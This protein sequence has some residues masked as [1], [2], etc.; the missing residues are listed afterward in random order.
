MV[1]ALVFLGLTARTVDLPAGHYTVDEVCIAAREAGLDCSVLSNVKDRVFAARLVAVEPLAALKAL[2]AAAGDLEVKEE[3][4]DGRTV[5]TVQ[6]DLKKRAENDALSARVFKELIDQCK[7]D[8]ES[9]RRLRP[10]VASMSPEDRKTNYR[11]L[12]EESNIVRD[13][14]ARDLDNL[15]LKERLDEL[16]VLMSVYST[17]DRPWNA[18]ALAAIEIAQGQF[19]ASFHEAEQWA[20]R[21][22]AHPAMESLVRLAPSSAQVIDVGV[23]MHQS[24]DATVLSLRPFVWIAETSKTDSDFLPVSGRINLTD[25]E[26]PDFS[27]HFAQTCAHFKKID[28]VVPEVKF[29]ATA[30]KRVV[31]VKIGQPVRELSRA[32]LLWAD[33]AQEN[34]VCE[35]LPGAEALS[36]GLQQDRSVSLAEIAGLAGKWSMTE[37]ESILIFDCLTRPLEDAGAPVLAARD[38]GLL[39]WKS[40]PDPN[41]PTLAKLKAY[42]LAAFKHGGTWGLRTRSED[43]RYYGTDN[44]LWNDI[45]FDIGVADALGL[46]GDTEKPKQGRFEFASVNRQKLRQMFD[47]QMRVEGRPNSRHPDV[48]TLLLG[49]TYSFGY[50]ATSKIGSTYVDRG[51]RDSLLQGLFGSTRFTVELKLD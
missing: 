20:M 38:S 32:L 12:V 2:A 28:F 18:L 47:Y 10:A 29:P 8:L 13:Q 17:F 14:L 7:S 50:D 9:I 35:L 27:H 40:I 49:T 25:C 46:L 30:A 24:F 33:G 48:F 1:A 45:V 4:R 42:A 31:L 15:S 44:F 37:R 19:P 16:Q 43:Y 51:V 41:Y 21:F 34:A 26:R 22:A 23:E 11:Q 5:Y 39:K 36:E 6:V 3:V